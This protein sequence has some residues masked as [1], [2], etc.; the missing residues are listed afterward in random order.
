MPT[1]RRMVGVEVF[2]SPK[3]K[4]LLAVNP[5]LKMITTQPAVSAN[6]RQL[7]H[8]DRGKHVGHIDRYL[9]K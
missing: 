9:I 5:T 4:A 6:P 2:A 1:M 3:A 7:F 8:V